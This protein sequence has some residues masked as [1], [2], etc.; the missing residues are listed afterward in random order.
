LAGYISGDTLVYCHVS[1]DDVIAG[2]F[3]A[4]AEDV[5]CDKY[6]PILF[7]RRPLHDDWK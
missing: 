4:F 2:I 5:H 3:R 7:N 1:P 6:V